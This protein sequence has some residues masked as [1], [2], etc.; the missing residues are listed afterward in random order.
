MNLVIAFL[1]MFVFFAGIGA[2]TAP[3]RAQVD[4]VEKTYPAAGQLRPGD[5]IVAIDGKRGPYHAVAPDLLAPVRRSPPK[6]R[7]QASE[8]ANVLIRRNGS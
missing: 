2:E 4:V 3:K 1:L 6:A 8:P 5:R 7:C